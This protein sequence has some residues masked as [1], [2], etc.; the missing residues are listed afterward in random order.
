MLTSSEQLLCLLPPWPRCERWCG[1]GG[2]WQ[3]G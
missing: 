1:E 2:V 3:E